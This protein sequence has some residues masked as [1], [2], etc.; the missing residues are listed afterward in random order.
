MHRESIKAHRISGAKCFRRMHF[1]AY[2]SGRRAQIY[3]AYIMR[4]EDHLARTRVNDGLLEA[5]SKTVQ[6]YGI[7][8]MA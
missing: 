1:A 2:R 5:A 6:S 4:I 8:L 3:S 7:I